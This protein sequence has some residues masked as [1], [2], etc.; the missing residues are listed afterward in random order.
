M[1][2]YSRIDLF[3]VRVRPEKAAEVA[4]AIASARR[5][6]DRAFGVAALLLEDGE[7]WWDWDYGTSDV[8]KWR[9]DEP[10]VALLASWCER[11]CVAFWSCEG[12]GGQWAFEFNGRGG[13]AEC[14]ARRV[15][16]L[17]AAETRRFRRLE[18]QRQRH[19][20]PS[21]IADPN[22]DVASPDP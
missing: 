18:S 22:R 21:A 20:E 16:A 3:D 6:D 17:R 8:Q 5:G 15:S 2:Y 1:S 9:P 10:L 12:D 14:S 13:H 19:A 11:G 7:L 4:E